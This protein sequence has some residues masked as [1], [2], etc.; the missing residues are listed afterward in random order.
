MDVLEIMDGV[1]VAFEVVGVVILVIGAAY[2]VA[3]AVAE[4]RQ[5]TG[6][7]ES[8]RRRFGRTLLLGL[9]VL[10]DLGQV[11]QLV[12]AILASLVPVV[13]PEANEG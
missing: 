7:Y 11:P 13:D 4:R 1:A 10:V 2:T 5:G 3:R 8:M 6:A 9:E 12:A